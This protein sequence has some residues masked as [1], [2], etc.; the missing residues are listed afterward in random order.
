MIFCE[1][2]NVSLKDSSHNVS[3]FPYCEWGCSEGDGEKNENSRKKINNL[4]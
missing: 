1:K 4:L 2:N 3:C